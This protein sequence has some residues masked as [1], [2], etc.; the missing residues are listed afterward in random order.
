M[1]NL[2]PVYASTSTNS[3]KS[4]TNR[5]HLYYLHTEVSFINRRVS[6]HLKSSL[7][8]TKRLDVLKEE[9]E[10]PTETKE[11]VV[12]YLRQTYDHL[13]EAREIAITMETNAMHEMETWYN[14]KARDR[15]F[16][17]G[18]SVLVML[19]SSTNKLLAKSMGLYTV[20]EVLSN[21]TYKIAIPHARKNHWTFH[22]N[23]FFKWESPSAV[24]L[25][26]TEKTEK[27]T[28]NTGPECPPWKLENTG[29]IQ[30]DKDV[31][32]SRERKANIKEAVKTYKAAR[33]TA[34]ARTDHAT[35][36]VETGKVLPSSLPPYKLAHARR[37]IVQKEIKEMLKEGI[38]Q[39]SHN[40]FGTKNG[41]Q[42]EDMHRLSQIER[43]N[44][45]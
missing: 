14:K 44:Y 31:K 34:A 13:E 42:S 3:H 20:E 33:D 40:C 45:T 12:S 17:I 30:P 7:E 16:T 41:R 11:S 21:T 28:D 36:Q 4:G 6:V 29:D 39:P 35:M 1:P 5:Y 32:L 26:S 9:W 10:E 19:P 22:I 15:V 2:N 25:L 23:M 8:A 43:S 37:H 38:I 24:C 27:I 18:D